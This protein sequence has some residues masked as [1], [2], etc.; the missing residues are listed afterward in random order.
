MPYAA[1]LSENPDAIA[2]AIDVA[3]RVTDSLGRGP[4]AAVLFA[5]AP[6]LEAVDEMATIVRERLA[7]SVLI[8]AGAVSVVGGPLEIE[9]ASAVS[10]W[11]GNVGEVRATRMTVAR[12]GDRRYFE[13]V[14]LEQM[15]EAH[16]LIVLSDPFT[17][18][19]NELVEL[20]AGSAPH[21]VAVGGLASAA[22]RPGDNRLVLDGHVHDDGAVGILVSGDTRVTTV[23]SQGCRPIG[24]PLVVTRSEGNM[25]LELAGRSA[26]EQLGRLIGQ[27]SDRERDL[28]S[29]GLHIGR[30]IDEHRTEFDRGDF[31]IRGVLGAD[32]DTG[33]LA[34][35][36]VIPIGATV[37]FQVRDA[38]SADEDLR[39]L[40]TGKRAD[41]ALL[42][43]CNGRGTLLFPTPH[44]DAGVVSEA[45]GHAPLGGMFCAGEIGPIGGRNFVH[46]YTA[47]L[48]LFH[49]E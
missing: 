8:G 10:L 28:A 5:T 1:A 22:H 24:R 9:E 27:L 37:Q 48:A 16:T 34:V 26:Y 21:V 44:H 39:R 36:D 18:P 40:M 45:L 23:V 33:G 46:G 31:L 20:M 19:V 25:L 7:P 38:D 30:V 2:A 11:A 4:D 41:G 14:D 29:S 6:H 49:D 12:D 15:S 43:T 42:F 17:F 32:A 3:A 47:S 35:G 13:G